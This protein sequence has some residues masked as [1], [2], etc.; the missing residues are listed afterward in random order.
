MSLND[1]L[2]EIIGHKFESRR[3]RSACSSLPHRY[4]GVLIQNLLQSLLSSGPTCE[5]GR[6][7]ALFLFC[8]QCPV[9][10]LGAHL[11]SEKE[12]I[13]L[14]E[15]QRRQEGQAQAFGDQSGHVTGGIIILNSFAFLHQH[16]FLK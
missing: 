1:K 2:S 15:E 11:W 5:L 16:Q 14:Q 3:G 9:P 4:C 12:G 6:V 7:L 8:L 13:D 10:I